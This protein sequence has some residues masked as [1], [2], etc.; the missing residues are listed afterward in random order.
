LD[1]K[2]GRLIVIIGLPATGK[3]WLAETLQRV[4]GDTVFVLDVDDI[5]QK[6]YP[7]SEIANFGLYERMRGW[8]LCY[9]SLDSPSFG[10]SHLPSRQVHRIILFQLVGMDLTNLPIC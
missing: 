3:S 8:P 9:W 5:R 4:I 6:G 2:K 7:F 10:R 1:N